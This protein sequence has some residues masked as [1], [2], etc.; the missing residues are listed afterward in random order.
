MEAERVYNLALTA[1]QDY[2]YRMTSGGAWEQLVNSA[3]SDP[4]GWKGDPTVYNLAMLVN[5]S[6]EEMKQKGP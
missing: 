4:E 1:L 2:F 6:A 5:S 3:L